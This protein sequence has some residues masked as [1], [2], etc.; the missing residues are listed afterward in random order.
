MAIRVNKAGDLKIGNYFE[1]C[2]FHPCIITNVDS[3]GIQVAGIS[4]VDGSSHNCNVRHCGLRLLTED[5]AQQWKQS[6]PTDVEL[7]VDE[8]WWN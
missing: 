5:E 4:L 1:S 2:S 3:A 6:G 7:P 8:R